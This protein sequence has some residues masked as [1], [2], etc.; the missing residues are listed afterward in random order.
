[1]ERA[2]WFVRNLEVDFIRCVD[3]LNVW[4]KRE[5]GNKR[6]LQFL[7][8]STGQAIASVLGILQ[9]AQQVFTANMMVAVI[10]I[11]IIVF[12]HQLASPHR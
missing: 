3:E 11:I 4:H 6:H 10:L 9:S 12:Y 7:G 5:E 2:R 1:M 8:V